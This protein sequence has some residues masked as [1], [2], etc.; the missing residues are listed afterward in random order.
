LVV[1]A[2]AVVA[3]RV[4][5]EKVMDEHY[6]VCQFF[7]D[8]QYEYVRRFVSVEEATQAFTHYAK[9]VGAQVGTTVRVIITDGGDS[10]VAEWKYKEGLVWPPLKPS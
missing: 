10:I 1:L 2:V 3:T 5:V 7:E 6:S 4:V 8:G 9:S